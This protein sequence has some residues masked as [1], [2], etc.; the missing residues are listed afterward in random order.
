MC[1]ICGFI[2]DGGLKSSH[3]NSVIKSFESVL[4]ETSQ[5]GRDSVGISIMFQDCLSLTYSI[6]V[7][8]WPDVE[9]ALDSNDPAGILSTLKG[10]VKTHGQRVVSVICNFRAEPTVERVKEKNTYTMQ[11]FHVPHYGSLVH[12]GTVS[13]DK[14]LLQKW[15]QRYPLK[16][17][18]QWTQE[19]ED[20]C[21][22]LIDS[23]ALLPV[24]R[25]FDTPTAVCDTS[26]FSEIEGGFAIAYQN[27]DTGHTI[28]ARNF[29][30]LAL[31]EVP[32]GHTCG[33]PSVIFFATKKEFLEFVSKFPSCMPYDLTPWTCRIYGSGRD[34]V[35]LCCQ[36]PLPDNNPNYGDRYRAAIICSGGLDSTTAATIAAHENE[37]LTL[38]HFTY[39]CLAEPRE[40]EAVKAIASYLD[41]TTDCKVRAE[42]IDL[43]W[44]KTLGG[45]VLTDESR[46]EEIAQGDAGVETLNAWVPARNLVMMSLAAAYCDRHRIGAIYLGANLEEGSV[47]PDNTSSFTDSFEYAMQFG[48]VARPEV[49]APLKY[50][51][52]KDIVRIAYGIRAPIHLSW[53]C[54][55][56]TL[57]TD[58]ETE[59]GPCRMRRIALEENGLTIN[60]FKDR[61]NCI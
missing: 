5:R 40:V 31:L 43:S 16:E 47:F 61:C 6:W 48:T 32:V 17:D 30:G 18:M 28:L 25:A 1:G 56:D 35:Q 58:V 46:H 44:L 45:S 23:Y 4:L 54:Y 60:D 24:L 55:H 8:K 3:L 52:K 42:I 59:C 22:K 10:A 34:G 26:V 20:K 2:T 38:L 11:P 41:S 50:E 33:N 39:G 57:C 49:R 29:R 19:L 36:Y 7:Q 51:M 14:E 21:G 15:E 27:P 12:N 53:S 37:E 9:Q 13:N